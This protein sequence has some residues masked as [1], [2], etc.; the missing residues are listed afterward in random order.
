MFSW[1]AIFSTFI[2]YTWLL[3][4]FKAEKNILYLSSRQNMEISRHG[5]FEI[6]LPRYCWYCWGSSQFMITVSWNI[7]TSAP[8]ALL[9]LG[10]NLN[11]QLSTET[12]QSNNLISF[13]ISE[14]I[15]LKCIY[16]LIIVFD[17]F[18]N[19]EN[20]LRNNRS[21]PYPALCAEFEPF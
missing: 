10:L 1:Y 16:C 18:R 15:D 21:L 8:F 7:G 19:Y 3:I 9:I 6:S 20:V 14:I 12:K 4:V 5:N 2:H 17:S 11:F 13:S